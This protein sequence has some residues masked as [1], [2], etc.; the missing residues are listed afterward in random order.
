LFYLDV[1]T[2]ISWPLLPKNLD[3]YVVNISTPP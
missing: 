2:V 1:I 3:I